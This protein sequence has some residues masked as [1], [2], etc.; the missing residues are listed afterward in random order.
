MAVVEKR[1]APLRSFESTPSELTVR[2]ILSGLVV[3]SLIGAS[4][5]CIGLKI[6]WTFGASI[7]AAVIAFALFRSMSKLLTRPYGAK[8]NLITA[9]AGSAAGTMASAGGFVACIPA[10]E[11][12]LKEQGQGLL[13]YGQLVIW[14]TA[15]AF[16]GVFFAIPLRKQMVVREKLK[17]PSG[18]AAAETIRA[19]YASGADALKKAKLL[20][21]SA[22]FAA[23]LKLL[24]S[25]KPLGIG[26]FADFSMDDLGITSIGILGIGM[27][28]LRLGIG[29]SPMMIGAG[30]LVGPKVGWSLFAGSILA[31]GIG[32][33][34][35][36]DHEYRGGHGE[37]RLPVG[38]PLAAVAGRG[39]HGGGGFCQ[40]RA[41]V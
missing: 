29:L 34:I 19:M 21:W 24:F 36:F 2:A 8:E 28:S 9:T 1:V 30:V 15:I 35:L 4:N 26:H 6:G 3:G 13:G 33:P 5:V 23:G 18:T 41:A 17:Y 20:L 16:L 38:L 37:G 11:M 31:W 7:T 25:I 39:L 32:A 27:A 40:P 14:A 10:L 22:V 12:Y